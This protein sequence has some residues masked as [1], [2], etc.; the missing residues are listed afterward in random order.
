[1]VSIQSQ[2]RHKQCVECFLCIDWSNF[3]DNFVFYSKLDKA[4]RKTWTYGV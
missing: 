2:V 1:M 4:V 3:G